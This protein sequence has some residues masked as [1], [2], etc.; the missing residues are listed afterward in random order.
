MRRTPVA[1]EVLLVQRRLLRRPLGSPSP[2]CPARGRSP[3]RA[4]PPVRGGSPATFLAGIGGAIESGSALRFPPANILRNRRR[5]P[6]KTGMVSQNG[7]YI[8]AFFRSSIRERPRSSSNGRQDALH[9]KALLQLRSGVIRDV[10][11]LTGE[12]KSRPPFDM[13]VRS[14]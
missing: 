6:L 8:R 14:G 11:L 9:G 13:A 4:G 3:A 12:V 7:R 5:M 10:R 2:A 1:E